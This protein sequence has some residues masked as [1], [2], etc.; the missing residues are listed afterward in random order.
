MSKNRKVEIKSNHSQRGT[1]NMQE[2]LCLNMF[3]NL[4]AI[5]GN[6]ILY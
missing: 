4:K 3:Y 6:S 1:C 5:K 2:L